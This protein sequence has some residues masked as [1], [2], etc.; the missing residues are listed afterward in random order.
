M[1]DIRSIINIGVITILSRNQI[2]FCRAHKLQDKE[3][4]KHSLY[5][6]VSYEE[7]L[8]AVCRMAG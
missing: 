5:H 4:V 6:Q 3:S 8:K 7:M 2:G 1:T